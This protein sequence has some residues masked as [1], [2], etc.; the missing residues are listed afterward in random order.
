MPA[1][2]RKPLFKCFIHTLREVNTAAAHAIDS[3]PR[4][5]NPRKKTWRQWVTSY[6]NKVTFH[7]YLSHIRQRCF[8]MGVLTLLLLCAPHFSRH[9]T[10]APT[11]V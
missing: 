3:Q 1:V 5:Q 10:N 8:N 9:D 4:I 6:V 7:N 11:H 2:I